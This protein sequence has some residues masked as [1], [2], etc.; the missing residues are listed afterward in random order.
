MALRI[1]DTNV[2]ARDTRGIALDV[3]AFV[4]P[5]VS[6]LEF[7]LVGRLSVSEVLAA[8]MLPWLLGS[9]DRLRV[10]RWFILL[11]AGWFISQVLTDIVVGSAFADYSRG[12]SRILV[13]LTSLVAIL[14]LVSTPRRARLFAL[15]LA[16]A[17]VAGYF[18]APS[19][20]TAADPWKWALALPVGLLLAAAVSG[21]TGLRMPWLVVVAFLA[22]G[23]LNLFLGFRSMGGV[24]MMTSAYLILNSVAG[25]R[26]AALR[27]SIGRAVLGV[28]SCVVIA[29][30]VLFVYES[31]AASGLLG[32]TAQTRYYT[33]SEGSLG[34]I[35]GGRPE[36]LVSTQAILDSPIL[37][38]GSWARDPKYDELLSDRRIS[39]GYEDIPTDPA[40]IGVIPAHSFLLGAWVEGGLLG[41]VFWLGIAG[42][43]GWLLL[44]LYA[45]RWTMTPLLVFST[46]LLLWNIA[47]SPYGEAERFAAPYAIAL[48]LLAF[49]H[50]QPGAKHQAQAPGAP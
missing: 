9:R 10:P 27:P 31:A 35:L 49:R 33:Q 47:F 39:L 3:W 7:V 24:A 14:A 17:G 44:N 40:D 34:V 19:L 20:F 11:W 18:V 37:G 2:E 38:H 45:V 36:S 4:V 1:R 28:I 13:T 21:T 30:G 15:G 8:A 42:M 43:A 32:A 41:G 22:F 26:T 5:A 48:C 46:T 29:F 50:L 23:A 16:V 12:L 6:F 25:H